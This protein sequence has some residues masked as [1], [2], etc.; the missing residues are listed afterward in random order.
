MP[1]GGGVSGGMLSMLVG[2]IQGSVLDVPRSVWTALTDDSPLL[3]ACTDDMPCIDC[4]LLGE[5]VP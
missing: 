4:S 1:W 5:T 3:C 2:W